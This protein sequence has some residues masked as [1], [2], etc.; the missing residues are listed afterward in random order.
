MKR[1]LSILCCLALVFCLTACGK[2]P[3]LEEPSTGSIPVSS[4]TLTSTKP[5]KPY[6]DTH[7]PLS[8]AGIYNGQRFSGDYKIERGGETREGDVYFD[9]PWLVGKL[10]DKNQPSSAKEE[11]IIEPFLD[12]YYDRKNNRYIDAWQTGVLRHEDGYAEFDFKT[13]TYYY[14][15]TS[16]KIPKLREAFIEADDEF[17]VYAVSYTHL[18][19]PTIRLV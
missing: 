15:D 12:I 10:E 11:S 3:E 13:N 17:V 9:R 14:N 5:Q 2:E 8:Y 6:W 19:L 4:N 1:I 18:T 16:C 7:E